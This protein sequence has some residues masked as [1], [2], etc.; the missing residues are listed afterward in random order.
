MYGKGRHQHMKHIQTWNV[1]MRR[2]DC[3]GQ[4]QEHTIADKQQTAQLGSHAGVNLF[5]YAC[6][7]SG[8]YLWNIFFLRD[9]HARGPSSSCLSTTSVMVMLNLVSSETVSRRGSNMLSVLS[10]RL[11]TSR[12]QLMIE[13]KDLRFSSACAALSASL[14]A[15]CRQ[16]RP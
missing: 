6:S 7:C 3:A 13:Y 2:S 16:E 12:M 1:I 11:R 14:S 4:W 10:L 8:L 9:F 15:P 5:D